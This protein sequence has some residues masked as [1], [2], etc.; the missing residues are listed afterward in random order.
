MTDLPRS[1]VDGA[2]RD[3]V[4]MVARTDPRASLDGRGGSAPRGCGG[5]DRGRACGTGGFASWRATPAPARGEILPR[6]AE[7]M[8]HRRRPSAADGEGHFLR[9]TFF[10]DFPA[11]SR[12]T[13]E[14]IFGPRSR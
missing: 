5:R 13:R 8:E 9:P 14:E 1:Y 3:G 11:K 7:L 10:S 6:A 12:A 4:R 2:G